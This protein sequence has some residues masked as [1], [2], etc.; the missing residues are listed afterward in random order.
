MCFLRSNGV[1]KC[2]WDRV[3]KCAVADEDE[4]TVEVFRSNVIEKSCPT[5]D[6]KYLDSINCSNGFYS[7][8]ECQIEHCL[9]KLTASV[10]TCSCRGYACNWSYTFDTTGKIC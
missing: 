5:P 6:W 9:G 4:K 7:N 3:P 8:S 1:K 2:R 10:A